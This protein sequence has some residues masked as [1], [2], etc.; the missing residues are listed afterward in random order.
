MKT[1]EIVCWEVYS[2]YD[3]DCHHL[4]YFSTEELA[5]EYKKTSPYFEV[6]KVSKVYLICE[7]L[8]DQEQSQTE[9]LIEKAKA[10]LTKA[11][12][13]LLGLE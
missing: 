8:E 3:R 2:S 5:N 10:K 7:S 9:I 4:A 1:I 6:Q 13:I 11:E 12:L